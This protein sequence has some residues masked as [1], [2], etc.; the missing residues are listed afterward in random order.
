MLPP[1]VMTAHA[2]VRRRES[3]LIRSVR[4][5]GAVGLP[6]GILLDYPRMILLEPPPHAV[7]ILDWLMLGLA[8]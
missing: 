4:R 8:A 5:S 3:L 7:P 6:G 1:T 2:L